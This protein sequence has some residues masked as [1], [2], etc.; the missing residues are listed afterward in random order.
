MDFNV[1][2]CYLMT[3][4]SKLKPNFSQ[5]QMFSHLLTRVNSTKH[6][7]ITVDSRINW[8]DHINNVTAKACKTL[9]MIKHTLNPCTQ[10]V[11]ETAYT[12]MVRSKLEYGASAWSPYIQ[13]GVNKLERVQHSAARFVTNNHRHTTNVSSLLTNFGQQTQG[14][15]RL[16][17]QLSMLYK[18]N[19]NLVKITVPQSLLISPRITR[20][21]DHNKFVQI[22]CHTDLLAYSFYPCTIRVW[23]TLP[24]KVLLLPFSSFKQTVRALPL[25]A[26]THLSRF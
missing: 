26:S 5:Y 8:S 20:N 21:N 1:T 11:K 24:S 12:M 6:L 14:R 10:Q 25:T 15:R 23:N 13:H 9:R 18:I 3:I 17:S 16:Q 7:G 2:K 22:Q 4:T 19:Q